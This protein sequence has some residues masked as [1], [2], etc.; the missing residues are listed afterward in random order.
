MELDLSMERA[1]REGD[2]E[3]LEQLLHQSPAP[4]GDTVDVAVGRLAEQPSSWER[5]K[6]VELL[7]THGWDVNRWLGIHEAPML[8]QVPVGIFRLI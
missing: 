4:S 2:L 1:I 7:L 8:R 5:K 3:K 6:A